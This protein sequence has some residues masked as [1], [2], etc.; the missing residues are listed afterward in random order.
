MFRRIATILG[1]AAALFAFNAGT[2]KADGG[3]LAWSHDKVYVVDS[4]SSVWPVGSAA[5]VVDNHSPLDLVWT[6][7]CPKHAQCIYVREGALPGDIVGLTHYTHIGT[8]MVSAKIT[9][10]TKATK[11]DTRYF[12]SVVACHELLHAVGISAHRHTDSS[13]L[14]Q[15]V[16]DA[17]SNKP[18]SKDYARLRRMY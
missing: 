7:H 10:D 13:C 17:V 5:E 18:D 11:N 14:S 2:A 16:D 15:Y 12:H 1:L 4:T 6:T 9:L 8:K 3:L